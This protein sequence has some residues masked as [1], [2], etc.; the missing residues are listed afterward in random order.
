[1]LNEDAIHA[2]GATLFVFIFV[3]ASLVFGC[4]FRPTTPA[5]WGLCRSRFTITVFHPDDH[6]LMAIIPSH[7]QRRQAIGP[8]SFMWRRGPFPCSFERAIFISPSKV[9]LIQ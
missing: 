1:M 2:V 3:M 5:P 7:H 6:G 9:R 8:C 4:R